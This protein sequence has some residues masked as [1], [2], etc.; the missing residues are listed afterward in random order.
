MKSIQ[1]ANPCSEN[2]EQMQPAAQGKF[3]GR[4]QMQ[5]HDMTALST[6]EVIQLFQK[7]GGKLCGRLTETQL[8][9]HND[10]IE[11]QSIFIFSKITKSISAFSVIAMAFVTMPAKVM[12]EDGNI[13]FEV[14]G[15]CYSYTPRWKRILFFP[16]Y[17]TKW[18][19]RKVRY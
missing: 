4:C 15:C 18:L 9:Q 1:L 12:K 6:W 7:N 5:V 16:Y 14:R 2:W 10:T 19:Y 17:Q 13:E 11:K 8:K 3:C